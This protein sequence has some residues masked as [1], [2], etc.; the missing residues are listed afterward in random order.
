MGQRYPASRSGGRGPAQPRAEPVGKVGDQLPVVVRCEG[1]WQG[2]GHLV[3]A[4]ETGVFEQL[5]GQFVG[6]ADVVGGEEDAGT[7]RALGAFEA[8]GGVLAIAPDLV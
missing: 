3:G 2:E 5:V 7:L 6:R 1:E 8:T 4:L